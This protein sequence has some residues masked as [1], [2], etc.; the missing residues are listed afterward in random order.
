MPA[1]EPSFQVVGWGEA[2]DP[3]H[4]IQLQHQ[5]P[6]KTQM[7]VVS[8]R[9]P[10]MS[11]F[12]IWTPTPMG[13]TSCASGFLEV[14]RCSSWLMTDLCWGS[15]DFF[16]DSGEIRIAA[17]QGLQDYFILFLGLRGTTPALWDCQKC[18]TVFATPRL[19]DSRVPV[20]R[21]H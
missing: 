10:Q 15:S 13:A 1:H 14:Y 5:D 17:L 18:A 3:G 2:W 21:P 8:R 12:P 11:L 20:P 6:P 9:S 7:F 19:N 4:E 16:R